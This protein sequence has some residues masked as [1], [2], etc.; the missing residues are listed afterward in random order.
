MQIGNYVISQ[1]FKMVSIRYLVRLYTR[2]SNLF[3]KVKSEDEGSSYTAPH[4]H[5]FFVEQKYNHIM[6]IMHSHVCPVDAV[7]RINSTNQREISLA[8]AKNA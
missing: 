8:R 5:F 7:L 4:N 2:C 6:K 1:H 3:K